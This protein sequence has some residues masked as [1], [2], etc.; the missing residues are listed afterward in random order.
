MLINM[1]TR[2][3]VIHLSDL[4]NRYDEMTSRFQKHGWAGGFMAYD[5][6][7]KD[8]FIEIVLADAELHRRWRQEKALE[9]AHLDREEA[10]RVALA[11]A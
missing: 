9:Q 2:E 6:T 4:R 7:R 11:A 1:P 10:L 5:S 3:L 8:L